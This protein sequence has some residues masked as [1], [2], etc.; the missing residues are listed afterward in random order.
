[1]SSTEL[2]GQVAIV[3][4]GG[5]GIGKAVTQALVRRGATVVIAAR[6]MHI[7]RQAAE[8]IGGHVVPVVADTTDTESVVA[9]AEAAAELG[10]VSILV[11]G[12]AAPAGLVR[13]DVENADPEALLAD[14]NTKVVGYFRCIKAVVPLMRE[15]SYGRI[16]N[17]G[18]LTG[19][20][21]HALSGMRNLAIVHM[22]KVLSDQLGPH[23]I[24]INT[25]HPGVVETEHI[26]ELYAKNAAAEGITPQQVEQNF[27]NRTPIRRVLTA[28]EVADAVCF[29]AAPASGGLTGE[30]LGIDG[31]LTRGIF[32]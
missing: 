6:R 26:H 23:G 30:S 27:I 9:M 17:I 11:N 4:G 12:A 1:M 2:D 7:L 18:G 3:T 16:V 21:S 28:A 5:L 15:Q 8:E 19:R 10:Q 32:L 31:G 13:N 14:L 20:S 22:T 25:L 24:T 29:F